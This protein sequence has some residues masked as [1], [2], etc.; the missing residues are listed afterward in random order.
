[1][2]ECGAAGGMFGTFELTRAGATPPVAG[3]G[4]LGVRVLEKGLMAF[5]AT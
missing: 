5:G 1:M 4:T 2:I 3:W